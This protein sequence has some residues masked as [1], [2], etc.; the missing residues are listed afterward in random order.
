[1]K[2]FN[3]IWK[4]R[5]CDTTAEPFLDLDEAVEYARES[6]NSVCKFKEDLKE[7]KVDGWL[8]YI[9]YSCEGCC[10]WITEHKVDVTS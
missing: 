5:Y 3:V 2:I 6:A 8:F 4:D 10:I 9:Q 1:M 7:K